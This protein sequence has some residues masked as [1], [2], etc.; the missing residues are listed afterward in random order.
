MSRDKT[1]A[2]LPGC[3]RVI[4]F[5]CTALDEMGYIIQREPLPIIFKD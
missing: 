4:N 5:C 3:P 1:S 2:E